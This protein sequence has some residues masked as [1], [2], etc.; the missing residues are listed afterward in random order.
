MYLNDP[1]F[2]F[3]FQSGNGPAI[4]PPQSVG[5]DSCPY[6]P[7]ATYTN[8]GRVMWNKWKR[9]QAEQNRERMRQNG[10]NPNRR[11]WG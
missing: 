4:G 2:P 9:I 7:G 8:P 5:I 1:I 10:G 11:W 3:A 6:L